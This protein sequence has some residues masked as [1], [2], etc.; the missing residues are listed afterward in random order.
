MIIFAF[1]II[2]F[3]E[4]NI[5]WRMNLLNYLFLGLAIILVFISFIWNYPLLI[6]QGIPTK[7]P[8]VIFFFAELLSLIAYLRVFIL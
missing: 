1:T 4:R 5:P 3:T 7:F 2:Y 8:W 6:K